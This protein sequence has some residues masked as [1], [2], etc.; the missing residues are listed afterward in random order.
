MGLVC[1]ITI[2]RNNKKEKRMN[3]DV[4]CKK[5]GNRTT[6]HPSGF[7][8]RCRNKADIPMQLCK[9]CEARRT[10]DE[11][12]LCHQ[13]RNKNVAHNYDQSRIDEAVKRCE[14]TLRILR[15]K[16]QG[17]SYRDISRELGIPRSTVSNIFLSAVFAGS[18]GNSYSFTMPDED[19]DMDGASAQSWLP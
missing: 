18:R 7:C 10:R 9:C 16:A 15:L 12:G 13:C 8:A 3:R 1:P 4:I 5:C 2:P 6:R 14:T 11:S 19:G 17:Q